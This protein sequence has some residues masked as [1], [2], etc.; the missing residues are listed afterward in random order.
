METDGPEKAERITES[1]KTEFRGTVFRLKAEAAKVLVDQTEVFE[2]LLIGLL[3]DGNVLLEGLPGTAKTLM[4]RTLSAL[5]GC[6]FNRIQ[7]TPDLLPSDIIGITSYGEEQGFYVVKG[8]VFANFIL[9]NGIN[10]S[11][12]KVQSALLE[13]M[14]ER[15]VTIG[16]HTFP[17][18]SPFFIIAT[19]NP[20]EAQGT[21]NLPEAQVDRF[22]FKVRA[23]YPGR[24]DEKLI[25]DKNTAF[26]DF[27]E[28]GVKQVL[29]QSKIL[30]YQN[31]VKRVYLGEKTRQY[32]VSL[33]DATRNPKKYEIHR[34][35]YIE[36]GTSPRASIS[37][38]L[39]AKARALLEGGTYA[40]PNHV[41]KV[42]MDVLRHR[43][44][45]NYE[46]QAQGLTAEDLIQEM[47]DKVVMP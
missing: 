24:H 23:A 35:R 29:S 46:G 26:R 41:K 43:L 3:C 1:E 36:W 6:S 11:P 12:P 45:L 25:L 16:K 7:F 17:L 38:Y 18:P 32:I 39:A 5:S 21:Y 22:L 20:M 44:I 15:Q 33:V 27:A 30:Q 4:A 19:Q 8:P 9:A 47:L 37:L 14:Q 42:A 2:K 31:M 40:T 34:G 13:A 28:F 10:R